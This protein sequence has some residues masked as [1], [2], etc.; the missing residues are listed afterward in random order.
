MSLNMHKV[1]LTSE[2]RICVLATMDDHL[3]TCVARTE[4]CSVAVKHVMASCAS[5]AIKLFLSQFGS[6]RHAG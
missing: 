2:A 1:V 5:T 4:Y 3:F 6:E